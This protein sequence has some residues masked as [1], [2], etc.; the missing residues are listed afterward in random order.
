[1]I[2]VNINGVLNGIAAGFP[3]MEAQGGGQF[4]NTVSIGAHVVV[5]TAAVYCATKYA[6][7]AI[8]EGLVKS[9][10]ISAA[11]ARTV[12]YAVSQPNTVWVYRLT[13]LGAESAKDDSCL[14][15]AIL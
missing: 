7:W 8:S 9:R 4:I 6:V 10:K 12:L 3:I 5:P 13:Q 2:N 11:I 14:E 15:I 1:M